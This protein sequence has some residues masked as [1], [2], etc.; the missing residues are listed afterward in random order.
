MGPAFSPDGVRI[1]YTVADPKFHWDTWVVPTLGGEPQPWLRNASG[2]R[3]VVA[4][5]F[6]LPGPG[7]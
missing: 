4:A 2:L 7:L 6:G 3:T 5:G 1:A